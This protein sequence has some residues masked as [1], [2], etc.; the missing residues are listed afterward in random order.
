[1]NSKIQGKTKSEIRIKKETDTLLTNEIKQQQQQQTKTRILVGF[2]FLHI[3]VT[4][5]CL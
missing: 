2:V 3:S 4:L 1:M 5:S